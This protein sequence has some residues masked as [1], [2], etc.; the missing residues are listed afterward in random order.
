MYVPVRSC[1]L[2]GF[3]GWLSDTWQDM[4]EW[5]TANVP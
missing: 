3:I 4:D 5:I 1:N 2:S